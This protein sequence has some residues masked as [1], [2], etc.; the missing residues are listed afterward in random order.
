M[1]LLTG[2]DF[3]FR[4][5][6]RCGG[7]WLGSAAG[8]ADGAGLGADGSAGAAVPPLSLG[9]ALAGTMVCLRLA[10]SGKT[11]GPFWPHALKATDTYTISAAPGKHFIYGV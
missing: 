8:P 5:R 10:A 7:L 4:R 3:R 11:N 2:V 1:S 9:A 6:Q